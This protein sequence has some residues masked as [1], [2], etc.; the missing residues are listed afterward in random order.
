MPESAARGDKPRKI[1]VCSKV[2]YPEIQKG[3]MQ[4]GHGDVLVRASSFVED[5][6]AYIFDAKLLDFDFLLS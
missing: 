6:K 2:D 5:G 1:V 3:V 4:L